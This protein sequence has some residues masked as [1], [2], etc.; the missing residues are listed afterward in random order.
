MTRKLTSNQQKQTIFGL[1]LLVKIVII[2]IIVVEVV[3]V[4][5]TVFIKITVE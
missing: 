1:E 5:I 2:N 3:V 4:V